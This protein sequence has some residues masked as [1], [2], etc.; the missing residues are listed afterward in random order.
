MVSLDDSEQTRLPI[1]ANHKGDGKESSHLHTRPTRNDSEKIN[2]SHLFKH[3]LP[4][5][6][7]GKE[8]NWQ[9]NTVLICHDSEQ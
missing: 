7:N 8:K 2:S 9:R 4:D 1:A 6:R 3:I 5:K